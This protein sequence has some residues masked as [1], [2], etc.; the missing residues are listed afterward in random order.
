MNLVSHLSIIR[1]VTNTIFWLDEIALVIGA[2]IDIVVYGTTEVKD[3][4]YNTQ[5]VGNNSC[6]AV[7]VMIIYLKKIYDNAKF[8]KVLPKCND[9][10]E[11]AKIISTKVINVQMTVQDTKMIDAK[12]PL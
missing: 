9:Y 3:N 6:S 1:I 10:A 12:I 5:I 8:F 2:I 11:F 4:E 7:E